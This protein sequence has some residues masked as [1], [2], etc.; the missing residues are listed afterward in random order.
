MTTI[1]FLNRKGGVGKTISCMNI[2]A[3][4]ASYGKKVLLIDLDPQANMTQQFGMYSHSGEHKSMFDVFCRNILLKDII[5]ETNSK[6]LSLAPS[7]LSLDDADT[8]LFSTIS[9]EFILS[10]E[11]S[12]L[13]DYYDFVFIDCPPSKNILTINALAAT[14]YCVLPFISNEFGLD[15]LR[16]MAEV[17][18]EIRTKIRSDLKIAGLLPSIKANTKVQNIYYDA[19]VKE[20]PYEVLP[21]VRRTTIVDESLNFHQ[22]LIECAPD[23]GV[24]KDFEAVTKRLL[25]I[26]EKE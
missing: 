26:A 24:T 17:I 10:H 18:T 2:G 9:R 7:H 15:S 6:N 12:K 21:P 11:L 20:L 4:L 8:Y 22:P 19:I 3:C 16:S 25:E 1:S 23:E 14:D 5:R 13:K